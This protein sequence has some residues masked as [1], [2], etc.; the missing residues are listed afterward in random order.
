MLNRM[1][2]PKHR[3]KPLSQAATDAV[4]SSIAVLSPRL[5]IQELAALVRG[6]LFLFEQQQFML[7]FCLSFRFKQMPE[8][9]PLGRSSSVTSCSQPLS[10]FNSRS[11]FQE[12]WS[13]TMHQ[14]EAFVSGVGVHRRRFSAPI[15]TEVNL[16]DASYGLPQAAKIDATAASCSEG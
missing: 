4:N 12:T 9:R 7:F 14:N 5:E 13:V 10:E 1:P 8:S 2:A 6:E 16:S 11:H 3:R 15:I